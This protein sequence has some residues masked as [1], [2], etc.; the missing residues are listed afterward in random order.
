MRFL[1]KPKSKNFKMGK[2]ISQF[3]DLNVKPKLIILI[4]I[5]IVSLVVLGSFVNFTFRSSQTFIIL[6][7]ENRIFAENFDSGIVQ[8]YEYEL[9]GNQDD[10]QQSFNYFNKANTIAYTF[11]KI[12]SFMHVMHKSEWIPYFFSVFNEGIDN[13]I[14]KV[15][16]LGNQIKLLAKH[17]N[18]KLKK[19]Q[20]IALDASN[21]GE[22]V[23]FLIEQYNANKSPDKL[24]ELKSEF[25]KMR[26]L[27]KTFSSELY[28]LKEYINKILTLLILI[29][30]LILIITGTYFA[31]KISSSISNP[32][33]K[34]A[35]NFKEIARG[36]L[37]SSVNIDTKNE[38][39]DM[40]KAFLEIQVGL[41]EIISYSKKVANGD[42]SS[43]LTPKSENDD[44]S[45]S[46]NL[47]AARLEETKVN[48]DRER[49][50]QK[51]IS[52]LDDQ[53]RGN[54]L[55]RELSDKIITYLTNFI[56]VEIGAVYV[57]DEIL[58]QLEL[59]GST[60]LN[61]A[62]IKEIIKPGEGLI[63]KAALD[64]SLQIINTKNKFH[65][66]YS[67]TGEIIPEKIYLLPMRYDN[68]MQAVIELAPVNDLS[69]L[70]MEFLQLTTER[71]SVN[72]GAAVTRYRLKE[73]LDKTLKQAE[74]LKTR[75]EELSKKLEE[76]KLIHESLSRETAL[77]NSMLQI[78]PDFIHFKDLD[79]K[80]LRFSESLVDFLGIKYSSEIIGKS[81]FDLYEPKEAKKY[82][83]EEQ[84]IIVEGK[85]FVDKINTNIDEDGNEFWTSVTKLPMYDETGECIGTFGIS[86][87]V[88]KI[89]KLEIEV[90][91]QNELLITNQEK[92][93][94][95]IEKM[96]KIQSELELEKNLMDSLLNNLPDAVYFKD[97]ESKFIKV[98]NSMP[99]LFNLEKPDE[100][101]G[102]SD[103]D[104]FEEEHAL[105]AFKTEQEI[106]KTKKPVIGIVEKE[107][108]KNGLVRYVSSTKMPLL[109][110]KG[111]AIGTF[112]ISRDI[113]KIKELELEVKERNEKLNAQQEELKTIND[114]LKMQ[115]EELKASNEE[116]QSQEE[117]LRVANEEL[118]EQTQ[119]L[120]ENEK[121]LQLQKERLHEINKELKLASQ[122]KS[123][124]LANMSHEL[125]TPLNSMLILSNLLSKNKNENL[126]EDQVKSINIIY[127]SGKDLLELINEILDLSKIEAGKMDFDF[128]DTQTEE[129]GTEIIQNFKP[130]A[131]NKG[132]IL[133]VNKSDD[134]PAIIYTDK[135]R[136]MQI[137]KNLLSNAFKFTSSGGIKV[138]M[139]TTSSDVELL[140]SELNSSNTCYI[141]VEDTG[142]GIPKSKVN[143]IFE[144]FQ[145]A[146][147][148]I[149][150]KYG[151]TGLGLSISKQLTR[152][153]GGEIHV[154]S[155]ENE[156]SVF[157]LYLPLNKNLVGNR[158]TEAVENKNKSADNKKKQNRIEEIKIK[159]IPFYID[160]D[161]NSKNQQLVV[162]II[163]NEKEKAKIL[164]ELCHKRKLNAVVAPNIKD[165][166]KLAVKYS[167]QAIIISAELNYPAGLKNLNENKYTN[168]L[169]LHLVSRI[170]DS[171][172][173][174]LEEL[175]TTESAI[176]HDNSKYFENKIGT[177]YK[178][179][180]VVE[181]DPV[182]RQ[183]IH[184]LFEN[185]EIIIHEAKTG[186]QAFDMISSQQFDCIILDLGLPD[187]SGNV[188]LK[189][190]KSKN[191]PIPNV[192]IHTAREL[193]P[194]ELKELNKFSDSIVIKGIKSEERLMDEVTLFLH[195]IVNK[196][197]KE[198]HPAT[199]EIIDNQGFKGKKILVV[200][201][202]I[203]NVFALAQILEERE[204]T[205]VEAENG[206][207]AIEMLKSNPDIDLI[208]MDIM[209]P[210]M[211][212]YEAMKIIRN[213]PHLE[214]V[215]IITLSAKAMKE[216][217]QK[218]IDNG[219]NDYISK[220][221][222]VKK[223]LSLLK[224]WLFK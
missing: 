93:T 74:I 159:D 189:K 209:M 206:E 220:P 54:F 42:F 75:D 210:V 96:N 201:D 166:I 118:A 59:T 80:F 200:D 72:I 2:F 52:G 37:K 162:L 48:N 36:N 219:A 149:S 144:A 165:G 79:C 50:L 81:D 15:E 104:F 193:M 148:S 14:K 139:G 213:T 115:Q 43:K 119:I 180:L 89:K 102:K 128:T 179:V 151:G 167:P 224:I 129:I 67:A 114:Q 145:Q 9:S 44:L 160:D 163:H 3:S 190:L 5:F 155:I 108:F 64:N 192:I 194:D 183:S 130:V 83:E 170:E 147:G 94:N 196:L 133:E 202:D 117:E 134:F 105:P 63:G 204:I 66:I 25:K 39:G 203:R 8:F 28:A 135:Q 33:N 110:E 49:W 124:F 137:I 24:A 208:L 103:F 138:N 113:T 168:R 217:Y 60:G 34:L 123:E 38:I 70:K 107:T 141:S 184:T 53:M 31:A 126:T 18:K 69:E 65:K 191:I 131:E 29:L 176:L 16:F 76:N 41:Q 223:L 175:K 71:I 26:L 174:D 77:L 45:I 150:R 11:A 152:V 132:L 216:D 40:S 215:P 116:L 61:T 13:D 99:K 6:V 30:V 212:G 109:N 140:N 47:M 17:E 91:S 205:V 181:D 55:V 127:K 88:T 68:R 106:I 7:N 35:E 177:E 32:I 182:T 218:A 56:E 20:V 10:L 157:T 161:R 92:L 188:L 186:Q 158:Q 136:L 197:P 156:G 199:Y 222:D 143:A 120:T 62:E 86:K 198:M 146:D 58:E 171:I 21:L 100:L 121:N 97:K 82:F 154:K 12:D 221:V 57:Y 1:S 207:V 84:K 73:L 142:I 90:K 173:D 185:K 98:S 112:G 51:G 46:L 125:R 187:F 178:Q 122:Y 19:I 164:V 4:C 27:T 78:I 101:Y 23:V 85:G 95:T 111:E 169:P 22:H 195:Q 214:N 153:L 87:D 211:D 172:F